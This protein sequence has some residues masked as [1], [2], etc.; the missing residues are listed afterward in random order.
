MDQG[1]VARRPPVHGG[2]G[3]DRVAGQDDVLALLAH[4]VRALD[5]REVDIALGLELGDLTGPGRYA[6]RER[7]PRRPVPGLPWG[8]R[9]EEVAR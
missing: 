7:P 1:P 3:G 2:P 8:E 9:S 5:R 6:A 4:T